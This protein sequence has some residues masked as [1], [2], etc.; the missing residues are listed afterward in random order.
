MKKILITCIKWYQITPIHTHSLCR[1]TPTCSN[2]MI[3]SIEKF[4][5]IK[6]LF[7]GIKRILRCHPFGKYGYD[8]V[9]G[10]K[11]EKII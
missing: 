9:K 10:E 11:N 6:G 4:G 3:E 2:Y 8:P 7:N 1:F 5:V